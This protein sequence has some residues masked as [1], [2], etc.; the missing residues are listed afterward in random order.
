MNSPV[1]K[2]L[3]AVVAC[4]AI[5]AGTGSALA[6]NRY[7]DHE[8]TDRFLITLGGYSQT[9]IRTTIRIDAKTPEGA[10]GAGTVIALE[11]LF[12]LDDEVTTA[13]LDGWYRFNKRHRIGWTFWR[14]ERTGLSTYN[15][16]ETIEIGDVVI[17]PGDF[18]ATDDV[19]HLYAVN[20]SYSFVN[21]SKYEAWVGAGLN[22]QKID[23][24]LD[25]SVGGGGGQFQEEAKA[26]VP[27]PTLNFGGRWNF[28]KRWRLLLMQ[29]V[30]GIKIGDF[31]GKLD[32]TRIL[33]EFNITPN[34]GIGGG[35]ERFSL[36]V[37]AEGDEFVG[38]LDTSYSAFT[39]Y[40]KGQF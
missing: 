3:L 6:Q 9:D 32:D 12:D 21:T 26:T 16:D 30:F 33:V 23:K 7:D 35:V 24:M 27:I 8:L 17:D 29:Q 38:Q 28:N 2:T 13:R 14:T 40:L 25:I 34:F 18:V 22:F 37:E 1:H 31:S 15:G 36:E 20:W 5:C 39:L 19:S 4:A 11:S 10:I